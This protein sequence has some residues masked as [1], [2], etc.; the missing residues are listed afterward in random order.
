MQ[1]VSSSFFFALQYPRNGPIGM[2]SVPKWWGNTVYMKTTD[3]TGVPFKSLPQGGRF[4]RY[5]K[6]LDTCGSFVSIV[7]I[8]YNGIEV[9][10]GTSKEKE[11]KRHGHETGVG[12]SEGT[13]VRAS[14][15]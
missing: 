15:V 2:G 6:V 10:H 5:Y 3:Y 14:S 4:G 13:T 7:P 1:W 9:R 12:L 8:R 11:R